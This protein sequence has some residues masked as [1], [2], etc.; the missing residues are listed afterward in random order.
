MFDTPTNCSTVPDAVH[1]DAGVA[2][3][4]VSLNFRDHLCS[5]D[6]NTDPTLV[7]HHKLHLPIPERNHHSSWLAQVHLGPS[8]PQ[9]PT[10][11]LRPANCHRHRDSIDRSRE[12]AHHGAL[13]FFHHLAAVAPFHGHEFGDSSC[14]GQRLQT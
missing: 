5:T 4:G 11:L 13:S 2:G 1:T 14:F 12:N 10:V 3:A 9:A 7:H 8:M 6:H